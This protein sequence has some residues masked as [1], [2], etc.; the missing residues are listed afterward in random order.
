[1]PSDFDGLKTKSRKI[2]NGPRNYRVGTQGA[3]QG[4]TY[5]EFNMDSDGSNMSYG[6]QVTLT[7][8]HPWPPHQRSLEDIGGPFKTTRVYMTD[9]PGGKPLN[10]EDLPYRTAQSLNFGNA[11]SSG[12]WP[13]GYSYEAH[14]LPGIITNLNTYWSGVTNPASTE[15]HLQALG[16]TA[17]ARCKPT[18]S[19][20]NLSVALAELYRE[21]LPKSPGHTLWESRN[22][23]AR[24]AGS[25]YLNTVFGWLPLVNDIKDVAKAA[26]SQDK[27]WRQYQRDVGRVVRRGYGFPAEKTTSQITTA[28]NRT[29]VPT[30]NSF[31]D[32]TKGTYTQTRRTQRD[33]WFSGAFTY[34]LPKAEGKGALG[35]WFNSLQKLR[36]IYGL[37]LDPEVVWNLAPWSWA[38]DWFANTGDVLA[39]ISDIM[40]DGLVMHYGYIMEHVVECD[41]HSL[42][43]YRPQKGTLNHDLKLYVVRETKQRLKASPYGFGL[44]WESFSPRQLAILAALG[45]SKFP[46]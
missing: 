26:S 24:G 39:N 19:I 17:I 31:V 21:G 7:D 6:S 40:T 46:K 38:A 41:E 4:P 45:I 20:A 37:T 3:A 35:K 2:S 30:T 12:S 5:T 11:N 23:I 25:E 34:Y 29:P 36:V 32:L 14:F 10:W 8:G 18:N 13:I 44:T 43:G 22:N 15:A 42:V 1:M 33:V 27:V 16:A 9:R 28:T